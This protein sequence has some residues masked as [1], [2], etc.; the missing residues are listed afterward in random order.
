VV[1]GDTAIDYSQPLAIATAAIATLQV[2]QA[3]GARSPADRAMAM[4]DAAHDAF[5]Q[6]NYLQALVQCDQ[7]IASQPKNLV[8]HEFRGLT[9]FALGRYKEAAGPIHAVLSIKPGWDWTTLCSLYADVNT[10]TEQLRA[11]EHYVTANPNATEARFLLVY[12]YMTCGY[13]EA[14]VRQLAAVMQQSPKDQLSA[15]LLSALTTVK[16]VPQPGPSAPAKPVQ[17]AALAGAW[18]ATRADGAIITL[19]LEKDAKYTWTFAAKDKP[20]QFSGAYTVADNLLVFNSGDKPVIIGRVTMLAEDR[21]NFKLPGN[22][23][24]DAGLIFAK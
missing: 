8:A 15:Q 18:K 21:F 17:A 9:L 23:P 22:N 20:Q 3:D 16:P 12:Q 11:L 5:T 1:F 6:G 14:A 2:T 13:G 4:L 7:A 24:N 19:N 10:Y